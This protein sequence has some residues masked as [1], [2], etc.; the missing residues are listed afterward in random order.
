M[1]ED[2]CHPLHGYLRY[3]RRTRQGTGY[4]NPGKDTSESKLILDLSSTP[5]N[6]SKKVSRWDELSSGGF[7]VEQRGT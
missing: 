3:A 5:S 2:N 4:A 1:A 6:T 7:D